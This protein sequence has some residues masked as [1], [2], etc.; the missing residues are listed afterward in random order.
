MKCSTNIPG[1]KKLLQIYSKE[2]G[3]WDLLKSSVWEF[4]H[5]SVAFFCV[6][7][8]MGKHQKVQKPLQNRHM[9]AIKVRLTD[10]ITSNSYSLRKESLSIKTSLPDPWI[11]KKVSHCCLSIIVSLL[12]SKNF[13]YVLYTLCYSRKWISDICHVMFAGTKT[14]YLFKNCFKLPKQCNEKILIYQR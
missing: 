1:R 3:R 12:I 5:W 11:C 6:M 14:H 7:V 8:L 10:S 9:H 4:L 2:C 13:L